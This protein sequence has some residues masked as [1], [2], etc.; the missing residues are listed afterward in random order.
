GLT[1][2]ARYQGPTGSA[3]TGILASP[4]THAII[5][6]VLATPEPLAYVSVATSRRGRV[7][8][9]RGGVAPC[10]GSV[11]LRARAGGFTATRR[12]AL[13]GCRYRA[14]VRLPRGTRHVSVTA[15]FGD[16]VA[17]TRR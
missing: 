12:L 3:H 17:T 5:A 11:V 7:L 6:S 16:A 8:R 9:I 1:G 4:E 13:R 14:S 10:S 15:R 2:Q